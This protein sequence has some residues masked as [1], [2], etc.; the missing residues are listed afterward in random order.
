MVKDSLVQSR[1]ENFVRQY[2]NLS[3]KGGGSVINGESEE[4][5]EGGYNGEAL[6]RGVKR[7]NSDS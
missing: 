3:I 6:R 4:N 1:L 5:S 2:P 7:G